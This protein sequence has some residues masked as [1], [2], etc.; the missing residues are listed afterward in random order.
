MHQQLIDTFK[1]MSIAQ[2]INI[3]ADIAISTRKSYKKFIVDSEKVLSYNG[4]YTGKGNG[5]TLY[6]NMEKSRKQ[7]TDMLEQLKKLVKEI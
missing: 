2:Q 3:I 5:S 4:I 7:Y 1:K 6:A